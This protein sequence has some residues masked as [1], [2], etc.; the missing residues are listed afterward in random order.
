MVDEE[1]NPLPEASADDLLSPAL[2][3]RYAQSTSDTN[4]LNAGIEAYNFIYRH[5][6]PEVKPKLKD[7]QGRDIKHP[8][9]FIP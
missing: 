9:A 2:K 4:M 8:D 1:G 7:D 5:L 3:E 6:S